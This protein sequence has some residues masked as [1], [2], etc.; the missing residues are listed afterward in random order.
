MNITIMKYSKIN[1]IFFFIFSLLWSINSQG[2]TKNNT[3]S[4]VKEKISITTDRDIYFKDETIFF[5][6]DYVVN[7]VKV[8]P[9]LSQIIYVEL[10]NCQTNTAII[11]K[12]Y[13]IDNFSITGIFKIPNDITSGNY[14]LR[15]YTQYQR[16]FS[17]LDF[18]YRFLTIINP[19]NNSMVFQD[20]RDLDSVLIVPESNILLDNVKNNIVFQVPDSLI[21]EGN[22]YSILDDKNN[23]IQEIRQFND[24]FAEMELSLN[25][26]TQYKFVIAYQDGKTIITDFPEIKN[27]GIQTNV[28]QIGKTVNYFVQANGI[29]NQNANYKLSVVSGSYKM[30]NTLDFTLN[31]NIGSVNLDTDVFDVGINYIVLFN[32]EGG[33]E[34]I[35]SIYNTSR[36]INKLNIEIEKSKFSPRETVEAILSANT[37]EQTELSVSVIKKGTTK[38][39]DFIPSYSFKNPLLLTDFI[40]NSF[41]SNEI[42]RK[43]MVLFDETLDKQ[44]FLEKIDNREITHLDYIP[45]SRDLTITGILKNR[46]TNEPVADRDIYVSVLYNNPQL[47]IYKTKTTGEFLFP[48]NNLNGINDL[49]LCSAID[50]DKN[51]DLEIL[52]KNSFSSDFPLLGDLPVI[53]NF[54]EK[55]LIEEIFINSQIHEK[56]SKA[57]A[58]NLKNREKVLSFNIDDNK[59]SVVLDNFIKFESIEEFFSEVVPDVKLNNYNG[60]KFFNVYEKNNYMLSGKPLILVDNIPVMDHSI[61]LNLHVAQLKM[62]DVI[63]K[64]Y[65]LGSHTINGVIM[66]TTNTD[67]FGEIEFPKPASFIEFQTAEKP[68]DYADLFKIKSTITSRIPDFRNTIYWDPKINSSKTGQ[69]IEFTTPDSRGVYEII[70][71]GKSSSGEIYYGFKQILVE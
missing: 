41:I 4:S 14:Y 2:Q 43:I 62:V 28:K 70:V 3:F 67:N 40:N 61:I 11:Q 50:K 57:E 19:D 23:V 55:N 6:A 36:Q 60:Q 58:V 56:F 51:E 65:L 5:S 63:N 52:I 15:A 12:K 20:S 71:K 7:N 38:N 35:N 18:E 47:H 9:L 59:S 27:A 16:N 24:G 17:H 1:C 8:F 30:K 32:A 54:S 39:R 44:S 53:L 48:L 64:T 45:E 31:N 68:V 22:K 26:P 33:I 49:F 46:T 34:K 29:V 13:K 10:I 42:I 25:Y 37:N 66:I 69:T 21:A